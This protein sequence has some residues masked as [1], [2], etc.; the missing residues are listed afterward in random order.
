[1]LAAVPPGADRTGQPAGFHC[2]LMVDLSLGKI[3]ALVA[4]E[5]RPE[6]KFIVADWGDKVDCPSMPTLSPSKGL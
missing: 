3:G 1:M 6:A 5:E 4:R 2:A